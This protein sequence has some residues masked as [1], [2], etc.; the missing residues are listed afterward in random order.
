MG[1]GGALEA[2]GSVTPGMAGIRGGKLIP[3]GL[4]LL[5]PVLVGVAAASA[6]NGPNRAAVRRIESMLLSGIGL[7]ESKVWC[8]LV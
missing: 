3:K 4:L 8:S 5:E 1:S 7:D 6:V 2:K